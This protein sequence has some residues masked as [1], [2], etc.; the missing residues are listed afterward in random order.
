ME[1]FVEVRFS[2]L[3]RALRSLAEGRASEIC[4]SVL[5]GLAKLAARRASELAPRR[6]GTLASS[7]THRRTG[8]MRYSV[9]AGAPYAV[10]V[11]PGVR[12]FPMH[13]AVPIE[14]VGF[15]YIAVHP[16]IAPRRFMERGMR[17]AVRRLGELLRSVSRERAA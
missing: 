6:T 15:R 10:Y 4:E 8:K 16:G 13:R 1:G 12:P 2:G 17:E 3:D 14:G 5:E 11:E 7:V 9:V